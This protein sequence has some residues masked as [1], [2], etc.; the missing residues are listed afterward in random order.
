MDLVLRYIYKIQPCNP[1]SP[2]LAQQTP[3]RFWLDVHI[4]ANKYLVPELSKKAY[5][6]FIEVA[7]SRQD[8]DEVIDIMETLTSEMGHDNGLVKLASE[9][10]DANLKRLLQSE[11]YREKLESDRS[12]LWAH[13]DQLLVGESPTGEERGFFLAPPRRKRRFHITN[14]GDV[15]GKVYFRYEGSLRV[16]GDF[17]R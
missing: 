10:R 12:L 15:E 3:W 2:S 4:T 6:R 17:G 11:R 5:E 13:L 8:L 14:D 9:L 16:E 1:T 7:R